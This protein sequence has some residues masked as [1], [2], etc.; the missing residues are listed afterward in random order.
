MPTPPPNPA[1]ILESQV[2][3]AIDATVT[4]ERWLLH[5]QKP[6]LPTNGWLATLQDICKFARI[7]RD[8][9]PAYGISHPALTRQA[10]TNTGRT[11]DDTSRN[12]NSV[13]SS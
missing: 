6:I 7:I 9:P 3:A 2:N 4:L 11:D 13:H 10:D 8:N 1:A 12:V 5:H